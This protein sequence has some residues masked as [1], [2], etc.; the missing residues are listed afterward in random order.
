MS[1]VILICDDSRISRMMIKAIVSDKKPD[2]IIIEAESGDDALKKVADQ[3]IDVATLDLNMPGMDG[4]ELAQ[5]LQEIYPNAT[6]S[7]LTA[8]I[9]DAIKERAEKLK[10][11]F[12]G[13][14]I[15]EQKI[16]AYLESL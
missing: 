13:K 2:W 10:L 14:P 1:K 15:T 5:K 6:Y 11:T 9:Q 8:N 4:L 12:I 16:G 3:P 7:L